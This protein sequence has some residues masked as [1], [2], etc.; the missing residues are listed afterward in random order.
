MCGPYLPPEILGLSVH[1]LPEIDPATLH[2]PAENIQIAAGIYFRSV[3]LTNGEVIPQHVHAAE[4][5]TYVGAG[6]AR[7]WI[8]GV[9]RQDLRAGE[10]AEIEA[11]REHL[12]QALEEGTR[13]TCVWREDVAEAMFKGG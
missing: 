10:A 1:A 9:W 8:D 13:L 2:K 3:V 7:L 11:G 5:A 12:F 4:H 6:A